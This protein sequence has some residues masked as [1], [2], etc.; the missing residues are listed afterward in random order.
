MSDA[1]LDVINVY[2]F[3]SDAILYQLV[4]FFLY[5][6]DAILYQS[7]FAFVVYV[8][9][10]NFFSYLP[11]ADDLINLALPLQLAPNDFC[12]KMRQSSLNFWWGQSHFWLDRSHELCTEGLYVSRDE[13]FCML[14]LVVFYQTVYHNQRF[15]TKDTLD[16][17]LLLDD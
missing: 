10:T 8:T 1:S 13:I 16:Y 14:A 17:L 12:S 3:R 7:A 9:P 5:H 2:Q 4:L 6:S 11:H 15:D